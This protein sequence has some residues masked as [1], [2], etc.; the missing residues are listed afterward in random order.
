M[1][2]AR[3]NALLERIAHA[4]GIRAASSNLDS[5]EVPRTAVSKPLPKTPQSCY[6]FG[7]ERGGSD[8]QTDA[9]AWNSGWPNRNQSH[10][11]TEEELRSIPDLYVDPGQNSTISSF[12]NDELKP[13]LKGIPNFRTRG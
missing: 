6:G 1:V 8:R 11:R 13:W 12:V 7:F 10:E 3:T 2:Q 9:R 5:Q 4:L